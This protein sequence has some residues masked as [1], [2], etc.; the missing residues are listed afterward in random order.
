MATSLP[1][2]KANR[3]AAGAAYAAAATAYIAAYVELAA[4][5]QTVANSN[6]GGGLQLGF[7]ELPHISGHSEFV[8]DVPAT[9][10]GNI[11]DRI[12]ARANTLIAS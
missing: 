10:G 11:A 3:A 9:T 12:R 5:D 2:H 6:V 8:R 7:G 1:T 4:Y